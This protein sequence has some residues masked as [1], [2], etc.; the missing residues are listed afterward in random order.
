MSTI[1]HA[2]IPV[3][4]AA[5][6]RQRIGAAQ[7]FLGDNNSHVFTALVADTDNPEA[8][9][10]EGTVAGT[11]LRADGVTVALPGEKGAET[12]PVTF[13][14]GV[15]AQATPCSV[16]L[17]Q[18]AFAVPGSLLISIKLTD[19]TT[20][21][22]VLAMTGTVIRTETDTAVDPGEVIPDLAALQAAAAQAM[23][24]AE[25]AT[26]AADHAVQ[27]DAAQS[28]EPAQQ[29]Q[30][31]WNIGAAGSEEADALGVVKTLE[32][33]WNQGTI[34]SATG[35]NGAAVA[36]RIRTN[37]FYHM[38]TDTVVVVG[39]AS[40]YDMSMREYTTNGT[41]GFVSAI[42]VGVW[43]WDGYRVTVPAGHWLRFVARKSDDAELTPEDGANVTVTLLTGGAGNLAPSDTETAS[44]TYAVGD[45]LTVNGQLYKATQAI[46]PGDAIAA[47]TNVTETTVAEQ[48]A[49]LE[50]RIAALEG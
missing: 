22:T 29:T 38:E 12:V 30:A 18:A 15:T 45:L 48:L 19:G 2:A 6:S 40:G 28:L 8:E 17:P 41:S 4:L 33:R 50:A 13:P 23:E 25:A 31:R 21:T 1:Y 42:P 39:L 47:G 27:Y 3:D 7:F 46:A 37:G 24:A 11:A 26:A 20:A 32:L 44:N 14:N 34:S 5:P 35:V 9:L 16:T 49:A 43:A 36:N 10:R